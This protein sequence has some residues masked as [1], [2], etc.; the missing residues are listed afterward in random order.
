MIKYLVRLD[1][2]TLDL[3]EVKHIITFETNF[4][5]SLLA[6]SVNNC[7]SLICTIAIALQVN[8]KKNNK[9]EKSWQ[10]HVIPDI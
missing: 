8:E 10:K 7:A 4:C 1:T 2:Y 3:P 6:R 9:E 5:F